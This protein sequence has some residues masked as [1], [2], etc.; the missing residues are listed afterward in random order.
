MKNNP[1][2][3][4]SDIHTES[5]HL[6][7]RVRIPLGVWVVVNASLPWQ[8]RRMRIDSVLCE[9]QTPPPPPLDLHNFKLRCFRFKNIFF[10]ENNY[11]NISD[12]AP[13]VSLGEVENGEKSSAEEY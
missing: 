12:W 10:K 3:A 7:S 1:R 4:L 2:F 8:K 5:H 13:N 9:K 6:N 11:N